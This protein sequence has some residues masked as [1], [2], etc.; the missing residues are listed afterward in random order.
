MTPNHF[1]FL[2]A[3]YDHTSA[4]PQ[5][6]VT[7][8]YE[9]HTVAQ[10]ARLVEPGN[11]RAAFWTGKLIDLGYVKH[12][13]G[14]AGGPSS[15]P[16]GVPWTDRELQSF[17]GYAPTAAGR[18]E[19]DVIRRGRREHATDVTLG[20]ALPALRHSWLTHDQRAALARPLHDLQRALDDERAASAIGA[21]KDLVES[22]C[23]V[24]LAHSGLTASNSESLPRLFTAA[25]R[26][27]DVLD[28][29]LGRSLSATVQA[30]AELRNAAGSGHGRDHAPEVTSAQ[31]RLAAGTAAALT[32]FLLS[33]VP[34]DEQRH[35]G[36]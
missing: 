26:S 27:L 25:R 34:T 31:A 13:A 35:G 15:V 18:R 14:L 24:V 9:M 5:G 4:S 1:D 20:H 12:G 19:A 10:E 2:V 16:K 23:K 3:L 22:A 6:E 17:T 36:V 21:A 8:G 11:T 29:D 7:Q 32:D 28:G 33:S 30:L